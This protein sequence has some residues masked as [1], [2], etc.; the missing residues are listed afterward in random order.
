MIYTCCLMYSLS[1]SQSFLAIIPQA[2]SKANRLSHHSPL[3][4]QIYL[5]KQAFRYSITFNNSWRKINKTLTFFTS[6]QG[7]SGSRPDSGVMG[8]RW[9]CHHCSYI[10]WTRG[11]FHKGLV[12]F[13]LKINKSQI[14]VRLMYQ[15]GT[16]VI[17]LSADGHSCLGDFHL[18]YKAKRGKRV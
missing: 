2:F 15:S 18:Q 1:I 7:K 3:V 10:C 16:S 12:L 8:L 5:N 17:N 4:I 6:F 9:Y 14:P 13:Q 11:M